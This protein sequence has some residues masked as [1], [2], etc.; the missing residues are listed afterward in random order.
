MEVKKYKLTDETI[1]IGGRTLYRIVCIDEFSD[2]WE[3]DKGGFVESEHNLSQEGNCWIYDDA[4]VYDNARVDGDAR[5]YG[6]VRVCGNSFV[7][8]NALVTDNAVISGNSTIY[9]NARIRG[10]EHISDT[11]V[12]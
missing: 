3:G 12:Y 10:N 6:D 11:D 5:I 1:K 7:T 9:G 4:C 8:E 2:L